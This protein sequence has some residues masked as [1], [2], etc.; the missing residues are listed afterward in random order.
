MNLLQ[1]QLWFRGWDL[2]D[3]RGL[4]YVLFSGGIRMICGILIVLSVLSSCYTHV[5]LGRVCMI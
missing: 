1:T 4:N 5:V 3:L 2:Y